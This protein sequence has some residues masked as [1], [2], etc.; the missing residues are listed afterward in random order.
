M[1]C[2][3]FGGWL[4]IESS[5]QRGPASVVFLQGLGALAHVGQCAHE[6][7]RCPFMRRV[8]ADDAT[9]ERGTPISICLRLAE[10]LEFSFEEKRE[11][12][13][14]ARSLRGGEY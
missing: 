7:A 6:D 13:R 14:E 11:F 4:D 1:Q 10:L 5:P 2:A 3:R 9:R 8:E 12:R